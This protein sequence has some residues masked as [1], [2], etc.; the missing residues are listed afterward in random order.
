MG[1]SPPSDQLATPEL[2]KIVRA[3]RA[4]AGMSLSSLAAASGV[5]TGLLSQIERGKG[6]PSYN[7]LIKLAHAL[8]VRV[9]DFFGGE[10]PEPKLAGLVK[11]DSRRRLLLS[12]HE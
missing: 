5:S 2:G 4:K 7:T 6:N 1:T 8:G 3:F 12:E 9:G 10:D 11:K